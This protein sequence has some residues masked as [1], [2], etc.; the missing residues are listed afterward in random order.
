MAPPRRRAARRRPPLLLVLAALVPTALI[1]LPIV[2]VLLR[3]WNAGWYA[4]A[5]ELARPRTMILFWNTTVLTV[6]V[7]VF[8]AMIGFGAAWLTER[9]DLPGRAAWRVLLALPLA[10]P[11]FV[12]SFAWKSLGS[13]FQGIAGAV[14]ILTLESFP[15]IYLPVAAALRSMDPAMEEVSRSLGRDA[16]HTFFAVVVPRAL[17]ALGGGALLVAAHMLSEFGALALLRVQT[18]TTAIFQQYELQFDNATAAVLSA[19]LMLLCLPVVVAEIH[20]RGGQR[21]SRVGRSASRRRAPIRL[22]RARPL[23][24]LALAALLVLAL[25]I[26]FGRLGYW[27]LVGLSAGRGLDTLL[28]ALGG[29]LSLSLAGTFATTLVAVPLVLLALKSRGPF[30]RLADR[31][32]YVVHG[33]PGLVVALAL[34]YFAIRL[35]PALYQTAWVLFAA[36]A[37]LFLPLAQSAIRASAELVPR[38]LEEVAR[39]LGRGPIAAFVSVTLPALAPGLGAALALVALELMRELTATLILAPTGVSTLA[40]EVWSH[41]NDGAYA[42]AAP[43][44]GLL[45][46]ISGVP[47]YFFTRRS[48]ALR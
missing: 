43:F 39:T 33:L 16:R 30:A 48:L 19:L 7:T 46:L 9:C 17:P 6:S 12:A 14:L 1:A 31:L 34:V 27:L 44:A 10:M 15:L 41:T 47:V 45:V 21:V 18:L 24:L 11:A 5:A 36:Y 25:G 29:S 37:I 8:A 32:P 42:A 22:G 4:I 35:A 13:E 28:P 40:T 2:Y 38:E 23:A 3:S 26:P 20:L